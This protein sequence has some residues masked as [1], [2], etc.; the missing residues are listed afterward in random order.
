MAHEV[1]VGF[2]L[3]LAHIRLVRDH[4]HLGAR[5]AGR[6]VRAVKVSCGSFTSV[7]ADRAAALTFARH[8][9][10]LFLPVLA[11][12]P[13]FPRVDATELEAVETAL[14]RGGPAEA[15]SHVREATVQAFCLAGTPEDVIGRIEQLVAAGVRHV[16]FCPPHGPDPDEAIR[17]IARRVLPHFHAT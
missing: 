9:L 6:D 1:D 17:L 5:R 13:A 4:L 8:H 7:S 15:A 11:R 10:S 3:N 16:T 2:L 14:K 12:I